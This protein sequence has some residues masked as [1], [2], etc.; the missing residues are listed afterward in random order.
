VG[1]IRVSRVDDGVTRMTTP[2][3]ARAV[4]DD[5]DDA[6]ARALTA[7]APR[8][9]TDA[10]Y[11]FVRIAR[12]TGCRRRGDHPRVGLPGVRGDHQARW[13][14]RRARVFRTSFDA[15]RRDA[16]RVCDDDDAVGVVKF[17]ACAWDVRAYRCVRARIRMRGARAIGGT[18]ANAE[19]D[20]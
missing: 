7:R 8:T 19:R 5:D 11:A 20:D 14:Q 9:G 13:R 6:R 3:L 17:R 12:N 18:R 2:R 4:V 1:Q 15:T 10:W 16:R